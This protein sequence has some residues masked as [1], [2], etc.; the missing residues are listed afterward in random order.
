MH[1][2]QVWA[3]YGTTVVV[4]VVPSF[5]TT[6]VHLEMLNIIVDLRL[7][8]LLYITKSL[9]N[10]VVVQVAPGFTTTMVHLEMLNIIVALRL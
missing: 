1:A 6:M 9:H 2:L 4:P 5:T 7:W 10:I 8:S 3:A